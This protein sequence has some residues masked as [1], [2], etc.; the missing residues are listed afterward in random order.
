MSAH[1][2]LCKAQWAILSR[3]RIKRPWRDVQRCDVA[4]GQTLH[5]IRSSEGGELPGGMRKRVN[6]KALG[7]LPRRSLRLL[8]PAIDLEAPDSEVEP[9]PSAGLEQF[10]A[11][12]EAFLQTLLSLCRHV[13][14]A[15]VVEFNV[16]AGNRWVTLLQTVPEPSPA[17]FPETPSRNRSSPAGTPGI[18]HVVTTPS[19]PWFAMSLRVQQTPAPET[20]RLLA[21]AVELALHVL[22]TGELLRREEQSR[23]RVLNMQAE[24]AHELRTPLTAISGFAQLLQRP[25]QLDEERRRNYAEIAVVE[26]QQVTAIIDHL[27]AALQAES[28]A[29]GTSDERGGQPTGADSSSQPRQ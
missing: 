11:E 4:Q 1:T 21:Q 19:A 29:L 13:A 17:P 2:L 12:T 26:S 6:D 25:G 24:L 18:R 10:S 3:S 16:R 15:S 7:R 23:R 8:S 27:V 28:E 20:T 5:V 14:A 22:R 9:S